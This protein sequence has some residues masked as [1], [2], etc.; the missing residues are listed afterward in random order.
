MNVLVPGRTFAS[1]GG[2]TDL[3]FDRR[4]PTSTT[5]TRITVIAIERAEYF[6]VDVGKAG[7]SHEF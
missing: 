6:E 4:A 2:P 3:R 5:A 1:R 7:T